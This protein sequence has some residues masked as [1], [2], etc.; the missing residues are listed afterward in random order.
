MIT[1]VTLGLTLA[2]ELPE[3]S[4]TFGRLTVFSAPSCSIARVKRSVTWPS[5][6][7]R[8]WRSLVQTRIAPT[9]MVPKIAMA[10]RTAAIA[11]MTERVASGSPSPTLVTSWSSS[12]LTTPGTRQRPITAAQSRISVAP[13]NT[14]PT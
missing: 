14:I 7:V 6:M 12:A 4:A 2:F 1:S 11:V 13:P 3:Q 9:T 5:S 8:V 10:A